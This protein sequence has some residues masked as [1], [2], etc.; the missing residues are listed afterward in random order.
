MLR[1]KNVETAS[2]SLKVQLHRAS[3]RLR[4]DRTTK[5]T[6]CLTKKLAPNNNSS[7]LLQNRQEC[8]ERTPV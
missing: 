1:G 3:L 8:A 4:L 6:P 7:L 5:S 2:T